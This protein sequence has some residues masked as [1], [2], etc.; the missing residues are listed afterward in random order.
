MP[1][2]EL[3]TNKNTVLIV[4]L[5]LNPSCIKHLTRIVTLAEVVLSGRFLY[6]WKKV[7]NYAIQNLHAMGKLIPD[8]N[9]F[10]ATHC[11]FNFEYLQ[12]TSNTINIQ[13]SHMD[14]QCG[15]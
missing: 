2:V 10:R 9:S 7:D 11:I 5:N 8:F 4:C 15:K 13:K 6:S 14:N 12:H 3:K 1:P